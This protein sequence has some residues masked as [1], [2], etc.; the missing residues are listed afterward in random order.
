MAPPVL[1]LRDIELR[2]GAE[3]LFDG[4]S[5]SVAADERACLIGRNGA[6]KSTLL[7][8]LA[9]VTESDGGSRFVQP[10]I[11]V[12]YLDQEPAMT[13]VATVADYAGLDAGER[14]YRV[15][16]LLSALGL[17]GEQPLEALS[18]G[19]ARRTALARVLVQEPDVL[20]LDEPTNHLDIRA[21]EWLERELAGFAGAVVS[22]SHDRRF[23]ANTTQA[24]WWLDGGRLRRSDKGFAHV[25]AWQ[26]AL[27]ARER[28]ERE[29]L[30]RRIAEETRWSHAGIS[31]RRRRN[32]G[33]LRRLQEL[34]SERRRLLGPTGQVR[35]EADS[36]RLSGK[37]VIE[38]EHIAK[39]YDGQPVIE[40]FSTRVLRGDRVGLIGANGA[41][42]TT[43]L[44]MLTGALAPD[45]GRVRLGANLQTVYL[46][47]QRAMLTPEASV[48]DVLCPAGGAQVI[49]RGE[50][51]HV[52]S[53]L[54][55]FLFDPA[56]ARQPVSALSGG[57]RNRLLLARALAQPANLLVLDEPTNDLDMDMLDLLQEMLSDYDGTLLLVSHDRDFLD[58]V[59]T[60]TIALEGDGLPVE[61]AGGYSDYLSQRGA[62]PAPP[63]PTG[64]AK[65]APAAPARPRSGR[66][67]SYHQQRR[68]E[69]LP[70]EIETLQDELAALEAELADAELFRR[71]PDRF[72]AATARLETAQAELAAAEEAWLELELLRE[73]RAG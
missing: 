68:L 25:E 22:I 49:V 67:L 63:A 11:R 71:D 57:E 53:Y 38:A 44:R 34:R 10:G 73:E 40:D 28:R 56:Q 33:R 43:L 47:Q 16:M 7:R 5:L 8:L 6:G 32:Q 27:F 58:R 29:K 26:E 65:K 31:A 51:R 9:G 66:K 37:L 72:A 64:T 39:A 2:F 17:H 12:A 42:K 13:G 69:A 54:Q 55:Q 15:P 52:A 21:I 48:Q 60:S 1:S 20:L 45:S 30:D 14:A 3:P 59:V 50:A 18:G 46:D 61:Y 4:L 24:V 35:L 23:L 41:G 19:Q 70:G 36:G 62:R